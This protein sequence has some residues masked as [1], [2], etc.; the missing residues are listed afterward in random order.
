MNINIE[1]SF[2]GLENLVNDKEW[3]KENF[4][5]TLNLEKQKSLQ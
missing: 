1:S 3:I 2:G 5:D 4:D